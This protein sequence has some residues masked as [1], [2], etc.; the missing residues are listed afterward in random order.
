MF[1]PFHQMQLGELFQIAKGS[2]CPFLFPNEEFVHH[3]LPAFDAT[4]GPAIEFGRQIESNKTLLLEPVVLLSKLNPRT[5]RVTVVDPSG[6]QRRHCC[7]TEFIAYALKGQGLSLGYYKYLFEGEAFRTRLQNAAIGTTNSHVRAKPSETLT[8]EVPCPPKPEQTKIAEILSTVDQAIEQTEA[9]IAKQQRIKTGLMQDLLTRGIDEHGNLRSEQT[10]QFKDSP[11]GRIPVDWEVK[12]FSEIFAKYGGHVQTGPFGSQLHAYEYVNEGIPV[13]MPQDISGSGIT[14]SNIAKITEQK[15]NSLAR[16]RMIPGDLVFARRGDLSRCAVIQEEH[17][18][19]LCGTG[20]LLMR[21]PPRALSP[22]WTAETY[23]FNTTQVQ[24][25][26]HAV[27]STMPNLNTSIIMGLKLSHPEIKEQ[28]RIED[29]LRAAE[30]YEG[31]I[32][33]YVSKLRSLKT[34]LMQD[35]LTGNKRVTSLLEPE[36]IQ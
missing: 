29:R 1:E 9:L 5:S 35:L 17:R 16:H 34:A 19:W 21:L 26:V 6:S 25:G 24:V 10:H 18:G 36:T 7:S 23:R 11:L 28:I 13:V 12:A 32:R 4:R 3:S 14:T 33:A 15:A 8:W 2:I 30:E 20:C 31:S 27:G 22:R